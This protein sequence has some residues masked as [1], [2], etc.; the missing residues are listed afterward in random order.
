M[1]FT[2]FRLLY[3]F[4]IA[5]SMSFRQYYVSSRTDL[6]AKSAATPADDSDLVRRRVLQAQLAADRCCRYETAS[7]AVQ[8]VPVQQKAIE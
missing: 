5:M 2:I 4:Y 7:G 6:S 3:V 1:L 8:R